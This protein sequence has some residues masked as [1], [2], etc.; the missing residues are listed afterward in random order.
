MIKFN[1]YNIVDTETGLKVRVHYSFNSDKEGLNPYIYIS[2]KDWDKNLLKIFAH[3]KNN[4]D[5]REDYFETSHV[6]IYPGDKNYDEAY[7]Q[8]KA[9]DDHW[10]KLAAKRDAEYKAKRAV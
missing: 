6:R 7:V 2:Q 3:A 8:A 9:W 5:G 10:V 4:S 1:K